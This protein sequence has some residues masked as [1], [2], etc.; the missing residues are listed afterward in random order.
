[1]G[2]SCLYIG[3]KSFPNECYRIITWEDN[4]QWCKDETQR[5]IW[6]TRPWLTLHK[7]DNPWSCIVPIAIQSHHTSM[8][9]HLA[10]M[11]ACTLQL[12]QD[13]RTAW[14]GDWCNTLRTLPHYCSAIVHNTSQAQETLHFIV[15]TLWVAK[16]IM[17]LS[18]LLRSI[19]W[20]PL[21]ICAETL[22]K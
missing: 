15:S 1:M 5:S 7:W 10:H 20:L 3:K 9:L 16:T 11:W 21:A 14:T 18:I 22:H 8:W 12:H 4:I 2:L 6:T 17:G 13:H 19:L